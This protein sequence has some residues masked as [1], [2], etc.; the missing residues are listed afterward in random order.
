[1]TTKPLFESKQVTEVCMLH[2]LAWQ[3]LARGL[4]NLRRKSYTQVLND[5]MCWQTVELKK[6][7]TI[8]LQLVPKHVAVSARISFEKKTNPHRLLWEAETPECEKSYCSL[9][10]DKE[11]WTSKRISCCCTSKIEFITKPQATQQQS[12]LISSFPEQ[13]RFLAPFPEKL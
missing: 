5:A 1:M 12:R 11:A 10:M 3:D 8:F 13:R 4:L 2:Y 9:I 6:H 7:Q